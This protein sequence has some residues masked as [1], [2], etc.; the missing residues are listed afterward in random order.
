MGALWI[1]HL[2]IGRIGSQELVGSLVLHSSMKENERK[3]TK[4]LALAAGKP[5]I[6]KWE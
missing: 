1:I 3:I 2:D 6:E 4:R 5:W